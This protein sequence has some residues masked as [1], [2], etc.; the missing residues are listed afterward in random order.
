[1]VKRL[2]RKIGS[3]PT[4]AQASVETTN[5]Y[6]EIQSSGNT[7]TTESGCI[8]DFDARIV[9]IGNLEGMPLCISFD[10]I[11]EVSRAITQP[12]PT[13]SQCNTCHYAYYTDA[14]SRV[15]TNCLHW[16]TNLRPEQPMTDCEYYD[17]RQ[18]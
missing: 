11:E 16:M 17:E 8:I 12:R 14:F 6:G 9:T 7:V 1:M 18:P 4:P 5:E 13:V 10:L 15:R 2:V 3:K